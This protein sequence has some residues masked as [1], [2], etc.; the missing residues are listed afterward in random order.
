MI[1]TTTANSI[2]MCL[3]PYTTLFRS[4]AGAGGEALR[5]TR[6]TYGKCL[7][8]IGDVKRGGFALHVGG[9]ESE[10]TSDRKSTRL[11]SSHMSNSY[12]VSSLK[13]KNEND[14]EH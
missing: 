2:C 7:E 14:D 4:E 13:K 11:N 12:A 1:H 3:F 6:D 5:D 10:A 8:Q 9:E